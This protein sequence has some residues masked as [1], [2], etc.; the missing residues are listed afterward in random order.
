VQSDGVPEPRQVDVVAW[1]DGKPLDVMEDS[2]SSSRSSREEMLVT[3]FRTLGELT[4]RVHNQASVWALPPGFKRHSWDIDGL[5]GE[6]PFW[7]R[8]WELPALTNE[9]RATALK[10]R[11]LLVQ[12]LTEFGMGSDRYSIIHAD[13]LGDN[14]LVCKDGLRLIDFDDAGFGWHLFEIATSLFWFSGEPFYSRLTEA[15][16]DGYR[17]IR[18]LSDEHWA[19]LPTFMVAR[20][21]TYLGWMHTRSETDTARE[22]TPAVVENV[23][24]M[25]TDYLNG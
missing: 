21:T 12:R 2:E 11:P 24:A 17:N 1:I 15:L 8:F 25:V 13:L 16:L 10:L 4:A 19:M 6:S 23:M 5:I 9:Q 14:I 18:P 20:G 3:N 7:G 22:L